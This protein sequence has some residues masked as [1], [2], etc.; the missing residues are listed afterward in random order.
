MDNTIAIYASMV[1]PGTHY[2]YLVRDRGRI[3][4]SPHYDVIRFKN[5]KIFMNRIIVTKRL[6]EM[7]TIFQ[8][9]A[10]DE[11][12]AVFMKDRSV[13]RDYREDTHPYLKKCFE[14]DIF[15]SKIKR[16]TTNKRDEEGGEY[17]ACK[18][19]L[20]AH[21]VRIKNIFLWEC[22]HST[23]PT[24]S[25]LDF[26]SFAKT[27]DIPDNDTKTV[28]ISAIDIAYVATCVAHHNYKN[29]A[30]RDL[31]RY[32]FIEII[33]RLANAKFKEQGV[34][35][36]TA[37]SI[38]KLLTEHIYP[39][40]AGVAEMDG[41]A[42]RKQKCYTVKVNEVLKKNEVQL[43]KVYISFT[44]AK[45]K[46]VTLEE[47]VGYCH[48]VGLEISDVMIASIFGESMMTIID[49]VRDPTRP[50]QMKYVEF[51]VFICRVCHEHY[52][53]K[54]DYKSELLHLKIDHLMPNL[55]EPNKLQRMFTF[56]EKFEVDKLKEQ[57]RLKRRRRQIKAQQNSAMN[58]SFKLD[59]LLEKELKEVED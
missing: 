33:L 30:E 27:C 37:G 54:A 13:F 55:L 31:N 46:F 50:N 28:N 42:F 17:E 38:E 25:Q 12:E 10:G 32:E 20:F 26:L 59:P 48:K 4:L 7:Q 49:T 39:N 53:K 2:F 36:T 14:E 16:L 1:P 35:S 51:I 58:A 8:A 56:D 5:T 43:K 45:K 11:D 40:T 22:G 52:E 41:D 19:V 6:E 15:F 24:I 9:R 23:Y 29:N 47:L 44:H 18:E 34:C 21:Y 3:F 57:R